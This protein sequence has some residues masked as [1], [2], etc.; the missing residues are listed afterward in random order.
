MRP[1][2]WSP[3]PFAVAEGNC[4]LRNMPETR[5]SRIHPFRSLR[6]RPIRLTKN[7]AA[8]VSGGNEICPGNLSLLWA[9]VLGGGS[10]DATVIP[11]ESGDPALGPPPRFRQSRLFAEMTVRA[12]CLGTSGTWYD[13]SPEWSADLA[14]PG[15]NIPTFAP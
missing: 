14:R 6:S 12:R 3:E 15:S 13:T 9:E 10:P 8:V 5:Q 7:R 4:C 2:L 11:R 1:F